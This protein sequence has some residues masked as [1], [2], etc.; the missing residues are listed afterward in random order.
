M[1]VFFEFSQLV[2][3]K[4]QIIKFAVISGNF[5]DLEK[6]LSFK[7][8]RHYLKQFFP[9][10]NLVSRKKTGHLRHENTSAF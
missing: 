2:L 7:K 4:V 10:T 6:R 5:Y 8:I 9:F 1:K 3:L